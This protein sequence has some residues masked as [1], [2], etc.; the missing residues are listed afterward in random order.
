MTRA[1]FIRKV[2]QD[3]EGFFSRSNNRV[4]G[5]RMDKLKTAGNRFVMLYNSKAPSG[6][7]YSIYRVTEGGGLLMYGYSENGK[8]SKV[9]RLRDDAVGRIN[10]KGE[11]VELWDSMKKRMG[12]E[13]VTLQSN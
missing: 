13:N 11:F 7:E 8:W 5:T 1:E 12:E 2:K 3:N 9:R 4:F 6:I 10:R